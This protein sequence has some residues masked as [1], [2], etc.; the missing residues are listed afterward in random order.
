MI[1]PNIIRLC[2]ILALTSSRKN[3]CNT[4]PSVYFL[5]LQ[6]CTIYKLRCSVLFYSH[7]LKC[8]NSS[9]CV[10]VT[11]AEYSILVRLKMKF[12]HFW[13]VE[14]RKMNYF[15][16]SV[17]CAKNVACSSYCSITKLLFCCCFFHHKIKAVIDL[18]T[19]IILS[20]VSYFDWL[21]IKQWRIFHRISIT[22][23]RQLFWHFEKIGST[24]VRI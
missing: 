18:L 11:P 12:L 23:I 5:T 15:F 2:C 9:Q 8:L 13:S 24:I 19:L 4:N 3:I 22:L 16:S 20:T 17:N 1:F 10:G 6:I 7:H 14:N 21:S